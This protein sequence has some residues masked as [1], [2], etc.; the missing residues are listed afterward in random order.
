MEENDS[1]GELSLFHL[2]CLSKSPSSHT[3]SSLLPSTGSLYERDA[4][5][6]RFVL[7]L[8]MLGGDIDA[9]IER[10]SSSERRGWKRER[11]RRV[12]TRRIKRVS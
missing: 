11:R 4:S 6:D 9:Y 12:E 10:E 7:G 3:P 5:T 1:I 2:L 8:V